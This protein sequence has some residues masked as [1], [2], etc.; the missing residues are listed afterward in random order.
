MD[1]ISQAALGGAIGELMLGK[2]LGKKAAA[3]GAVIATIPDLDMVLMP[4]IS[5]LQRLTIHRG[6]S[7]SILF[8][9]VGAILI[10][11]ILSKIRWT[12]DIST[13]K[14]WLFSWLVLFTHMLLDAFTTFGTQ[15]FLP[16]SDYRVGFDSINI[17]DPFY[18]IPLLIGLLLS[19]YLKRNSHQPIF[20]KIGLLISTIYLVGTLGVKQY[21]KAQFN[22]ALNKQNIS[23][24][25]LLT[26]PVA[27]GSIN[28]YGVAKSAEGVYI[29]KYSNLRCNQIEFEYFP[30]NDYLLENID[31]WL[32]NRLQWFSK[33]FYTVSK[34][35]ETISLYSLK[36]DMR[37]IFEMGNY[38]A[39]TVGYFEI[40]PLPDNKYELS[41][42][43]HDINNRNK[44]KVQK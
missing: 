29:G 15:L 6:Y 42:Q 39:P 24:S 43:E 16:V 7:H 21:V 10:M 44:I 41:Y 17:V 19:L 23:Y 4:F 26:V 30:I 2:K 8:S 3:I 33:G 34:S 20:N 28:W 18:T 13:K 9:I 12:Q 31:P 37:G 11:Y 27:V 1:S 5:D 36:V 25:R 14:L 22:T 38:K 35:D 40:T 32:V